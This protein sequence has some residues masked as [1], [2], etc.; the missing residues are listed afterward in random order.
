LVCITGLGAGDSR[1]HGGFLFD[2]LIMPLLLRNVY[3]DK[4]RQ[5]AII[6]GSKLDW[7]LVRPAVLTN[8]PATGKVWAQVDLAEVHG[9]TITRGDVARFVVA[10]L[11]RGD[12]KKQAPL[13]RN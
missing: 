13:I 1:G 8:Q 12:W 6:I 7:T 2:R 9:G 4:D 10:G 3:V 5:E 11:S